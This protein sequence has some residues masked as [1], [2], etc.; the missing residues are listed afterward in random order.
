MGFLDKA[1]SLPGDVAKAAAETAAQLPGIPLDVAE[2]TV[3]GAE[4]GMDKLTDPK[5]SS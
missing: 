5:G 1:L 3:E 2:K 4:K